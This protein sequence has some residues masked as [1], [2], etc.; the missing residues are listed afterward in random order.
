MMLWKGWTVWMIVCQL[1]YLWCSWYDHLRIRMLKMEWRV[2]RGIEGYYFLREVFLKSGL[3][4][5]VD[6]SWGDFSFLSL[7]ETLIYLIYSCNFYLNLQR[8]NSPNCLLRPDS[9]TITVIPN[10][11]RSSGISASRTVSSL[12]HNQSNKRSQ[13]TSFLV[14]NLFVFKKNKRRNDFHW[15]NES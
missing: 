10:P 13:A 11:P 14:L 15:N 3:F 2:L 8:S 6:F 1:L 9:P 12:P 5:S 7:S 4:R